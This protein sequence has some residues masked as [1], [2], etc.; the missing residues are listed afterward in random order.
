MYA[1]KK[2]THCSTLLALRCHE[3]ELVN[4]AIPSLRLAV[5]PVHIF[6]CDCHMEGGARVARMR[7]CV[8]DQR[9]PTHKVA[10]HS[11]SGFKLNTTHESFYLLRIN[12]CV[13]ERSGTCYFCLYAN[14]SGS[15]C[16]GLTSLARTD[17]PTVSFLC[18]ARTAPPFG[19]DYGGNKLPGTLPTYLEPCTPTSLTPSIC[20][21]ATEG[22][23]YY[24]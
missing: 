24:L 2:F 21:R 3:R 14:K 8:T 20:A 16:P 12:G 6:K 1:H 18:S 9:P 17:T 22:R 7:G 5:R 13:A 10:V 15:C 4:S 11:G 23:Q 19:T